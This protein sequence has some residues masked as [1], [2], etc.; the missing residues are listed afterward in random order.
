MIL[1]AVTDGFVV[2]APITTLTEGTDVQPA[3]LVTV[4]VYV[5][6]ADKPVIVL[7]ALV[8]VVVFHPGILVKVHAP[9]R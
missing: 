9:T 2:P 8:T 6:L 5:V 3:T 7:R 4:K 1:V